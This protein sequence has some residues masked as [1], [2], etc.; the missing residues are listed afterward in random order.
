MQARL[1]YEDYVALP[2]SDDRFE[3]IDGV[4]CMAP[5]PVREHQ[6]FLFCFTKVI[7]EFATRHGLGV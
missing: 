4:F 5:I 2:E 6:I 7:E 3:L 1:T